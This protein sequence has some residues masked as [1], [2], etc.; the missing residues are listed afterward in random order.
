VFARRSYGS[1]EEADADQGRSSRERVKRRGRR[2][3]GSRERVSG[4]GHLGPLG[5]V[6]GAVA[7]RI[8]ELRDHRSACAAGD[9]ADVVRDLVPLNHPRG[10]V[11][12]S[13]VAKIS[14]PR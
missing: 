3:T 7:S 5:R 4:G 13:A 8:G 1:F 2:A 12:G 14:R 6:G 10:R 9:T 11:D